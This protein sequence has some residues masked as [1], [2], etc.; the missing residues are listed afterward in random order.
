MLN[1]LGELLI[2]SE[3]EHLEFKEA[4]ER[5][6]FDKLTRYCAAL[7]NEG[8]GKFILGVTNR[9]PRA[10]VGSNAFMDLE[11]TKNELLNKLHF[12]VEA[13]AV[14][15][16]N[17]RV[18]IFDVP[19]RPIGRAVDVDGAYLMRSGESLTKMTPD[20]LK[21]IFDE[22]VTDFSASICPSA[23]MDDLSSEAIERFRTLWHRKT[24]NHTLTALSDEQLLIDAELITDDGITYAALVL[25][26]TPAALRKYLADAEVIYEY[27]SNEADIR[28]ARRTEYREGFFLF[29]DELWEDVDA[30][31][32]VQ[33]I[34]EG[35]FL[36]D[37]P[38]FNEQV[39]REA[40]LNSVC[41][42]DYQLPG[43]V[44][45]RQFPRKLEVVSPGGFPVGINTENVL[46]RQSPR[47][48]R[49]AESL[50]RCGLVER[51]GQGMDTMF[52]ESIK[53]GKAKPDFSGTDEY[54]V[55]LT[56]HGEI[57]DPRFVQFL[58]KI[59]QET[60]E[61]FTV[62]DLIL[63]DAIYK[64]NSIEDSLKPRLPRLLEKGIVER[65]G[66]GR[67]TRYILSQ[68]FYSFLGKQA[69]YTRK[70]G[71]D[72]ETNKRLLLEHIKRRRS[73]TQLNELMEVLPALTRDQVQGLLRDLK[74]QGQVEVK[75]R[76][77]GARWYTL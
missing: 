76:G 25:L 71:L 49:I 47:N 30:R 57:Q 1:E 40:I 48:R 62:D 77:S 67:G 11:R 73:G 3:N 23:N 28:Y 10:V 41:H 13:K 31:N 24:G 5:Y 72:R 8:G 53:E 16:P 54:F 39:V 69:S 66:R 45:V 51:S 42:R 64:D 35:L 37:L 17:G 20:M 21:R 33:H 22:A 52:R 15:H 46:R 65:V 61:S 9:V 18:V 7:A 29:Q 19:S 38:T 26:G 56:L 68:R 59:G 4:K 55:N 60:L 34:Q 63:L 70:K 14:Q 74:A 75:G 32:D 27:R 43:S 44:F 50:Q 12:R 58:E 6:S 2:A 36:R